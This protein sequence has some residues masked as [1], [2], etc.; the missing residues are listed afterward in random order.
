[1]GGATAKDRAVS[2]ITR[3]DFTNIPDGPG[4]GRPHGPRMQGD[5]TRWATRL[6]VHAKKQ[7]VADYGARRH[8]NRPAA[9]AA[10]DHLIERGRVKPKDREELVR[11][12]YDNLRNGGRGLSYFKDGSP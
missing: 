10:V 12:V 11:T 2:G 7:L 4:R 5:L 8:H 6:A 1:M 3:V 9:E